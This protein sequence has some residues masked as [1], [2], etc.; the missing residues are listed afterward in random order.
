MI[1]WNGQLSVLR[2]T[3]KPRRLLSWQIRRI[4]LLR[5]YLQ[6]PFQ[7]PSSAAAFAFA[8]FFARLS[9]SLLARLANSASTAS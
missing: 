2:L 7:A 6:H 5:Q 9:L 1:T 8:A 3:L 4:L